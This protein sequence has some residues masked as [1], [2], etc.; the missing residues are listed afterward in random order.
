[1]GQLADMVLRLGAAAAKGAARNNLRLLSQVIVGL[2]RHRSFEFDRFQKW[3]NV[4]ET[5]TRDEIL[6]LARAYKIIKSE[7]TDQTFWLLLKESL[8]GQFAAEE[9]E[10]KVAGLMRTGLMIPSSGWGALVYE[11]GPSLAELGE[12]AELER[13]SAEHP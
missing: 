2:K 6:V 8:S 12:L 11:P 4:L 5:L 3:A 9:I 10:E 7:R 13:S 1:M